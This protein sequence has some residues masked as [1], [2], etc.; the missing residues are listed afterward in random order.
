MTAQGVNDGPMAKVA[1]NL[2][3]EIPYFAE[4]IRAMY[5]T[6]YTTFANLIVAVF[7]SALYVGRVHWAAIAAWLGALAV[8]SVLRVALVQAYGR[9]AARNEL[10][11]GYASVALSASAGLAW[12]AFIVAAFGAPPG[13][14]EF[15]FMLA[16]FC[17]SIGNMAFVV[18][19]P[20]YLAFPFG[21]VIGQIVYFARLD[22]AEND[23]VVVILVV[24]YASIGYVALMVGRVLVGS[25]KL[26]FANADLIERLRQ[27]R[28]RAETGARAKSDFLATMSHEIRTPLNGILGMLQLLLKTGPNARQREYLETARY[29]ADALIGLIGEILDYSKAEAGRIQVEKIVFSPRRMVESVIG[30][31]SARAAE[32]GLVLRAVHEDG[33]PPTLL[34]DSA[35]IRRILLNYVSNAIKF[36]DRGSIVV[37]VGVVGGALDRPRLRFAVRDT[38]PGI[39]ATRQAHLFEAYAQADASISRRYGGTGLGLSISRRLAEAM[40]GA[41]G[42]DSDVG[43]GS[44]F[45]FEVDLMVLE[46]DTEM[47][48]ESAERSRPLDV[49]VVDD[50]LTNRQVA[51]GLLA[52]SG[53]RTVVASSGEEALDVIASRP[54]DLVLMDLRMPGLDGFETTRRLRRLPEPAKAAIP[55]IAVTGGAQADEA[56]LCFAAGMNDFVV[57]PISAVALDGAIRRVL[58]AGDRV[59]AVPRGSGT[60]TEFDD[61]QL[62]R[63]RVALGPARL[64]ELVAEFRRSLEED[65]AAMI[66]AWGSRDFARLAFLGHRAGGAAADIGCRALGGLLAR[67]ETA[68]KAEQP[69]EIAR[70]MAA[71]EA[72]LRRALAA[73]EATQAAMARDPAAY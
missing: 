62:R 61:A 56:A 44:T 58:L 4:R 37:A 33:V 6:S 64:D 28:D 65:R 70:E 36:T 60:T 51:S 59:D 31:M 42:V 55:V 21:A 13:L 71:L 1:A 54:V 40:G 10:A 8:L 18:W 69:G 34:G 41:V 63:L 45:W 29:S 22:A 30:L 26:Q 47:E 48:T 43:H 17:T 32:K 25:I 49:L 67:L 24:G 20:A 2:R 39:P 72:A 66:E 3:G 38:G 7:L 53:H 35:K 5:G 52:L 19:L 11:W 14:R 73:V 15:I 16:V 50:T 46:D 27:E 57:K 68:A 9:A 12:S 23:I